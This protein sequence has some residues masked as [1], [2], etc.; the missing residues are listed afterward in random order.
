MLSPKL[1]KYNMYSVLKVSTNITR[2]VMVQT[3]TNI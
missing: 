1:Y 2:S 3:G